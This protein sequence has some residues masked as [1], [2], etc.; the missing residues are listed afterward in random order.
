MPTKPLK[1][2]QAELY[3]DRVW[4]RC[5]KAGYKILRTDPE[6]DREL[7]LVNNDRVAVSGGYKKINRIS[8]DV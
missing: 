5:I 6:R 1:S 7:W 4:C 2:L 3:A 8:L